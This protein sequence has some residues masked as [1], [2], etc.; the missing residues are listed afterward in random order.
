MSANWYEGQADV[1]VIRRFKEAQLEQAIT[2]ACARLSMA[3]TQDQAYT[4]FEQIRV[5]IAQ[6]SPEQVLRLEKQRGLIR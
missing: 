1:G 2:D 3:S 5:L 6:R 4:E